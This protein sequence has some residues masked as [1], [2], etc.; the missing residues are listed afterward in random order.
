M[1]PVDLN[2]SLGM[3]GAIAALAFSGIGSA[4]GTGIAAQSAIGA[5]KRNYAQGKP[6][7]FMLLAFV[8]VPLS[9]TI[10][11]MIVMFVMMDKASAGMPWQGLLGI[12]VLSGLAMGT[13]AWIQG[14]GCA[15]SAD[16]MGETGKGLTNNMAALGVIETVAIFVMVFTMIILG[17]FNPAAS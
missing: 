15:A 17:M 13:S 9:Q 11:G 16:A 8:G 7:S 12:G 1:D 5:W 2:F 4:L 10:Y 6:A 3:F 14:K